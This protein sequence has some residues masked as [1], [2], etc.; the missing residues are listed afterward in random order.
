[1][2]SK[3]KRI[4][5]KALTSFSFSQPAIHTASFAVAHNCKYYSVDIYSKYIVNFTILPWIIDALLGERFQFVLPRLK[6]YWMRVLQRARNPCPLCRFCRFP[7][8]HMQELWHCIWKMKWVL[9]DKNAIKCETRV[10]YKI[11]KY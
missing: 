3:I 2:Q 1:M 10:Y 7:F 6:A 8:G 4:Y 5:K 11:Q 9:N